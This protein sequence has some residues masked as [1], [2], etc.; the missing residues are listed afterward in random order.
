VVFTNCDKADELEMPAR[1][2]KQ[3]LT[4][5]PFAVSRL[6]EF[7]TKRELV[8]RTGHDYWEW[9]LVILKR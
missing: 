5:V 4:R 1:Q 6:M 3:K 8:N 7:C 9:P 2:P